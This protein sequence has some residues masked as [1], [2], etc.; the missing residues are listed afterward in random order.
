MPR[1]FVFAYGVI[2]YLLF[3]AVFTYL[4][5]FLL[6]IAPKSINDPAALSVHPLPAVMINLSLIALF[7]VLHSLLARD[8]VKRRLTKIIPAAAERS[9]YVVQSSLCLGLMM[10]QWQPISA[11]IWQF[12]GAASFAF[13]AMFAIGA[14]LVLW[15]TFLIDHFEL[16]GLRQIWTHLKGRAMPAP[17]FKTPALYRFV[18][19]PM[20]LG[21]IVLLFA[22]PQMT[23][24]HL[25]LAASMTAY[26]FV[27]LYFEERALVR[28]FGDRYRLYQAQVPLL[29]P[30]FGKINRPQ[31]QRVN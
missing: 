4:A 24:G 11:P 5:A 17:I 19:H 2:A 22:T 9:T 27:G 31:G 1:S 16:F 20:Q 28:Q 13:Y 26:I 6:G 15:S 14:G 7:G 30:G 12:D 23:F 25:L 21:V 3:L 8:H 10:W 29:F 18:R